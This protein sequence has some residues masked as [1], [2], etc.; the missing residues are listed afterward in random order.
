MTEKLSKANVWVRV[1]V[2]ASMIIAT[3]LATAFGLGYKLANV[4]IQFKSYVD[5]RE[6]SLRQEMDS[7]KTA[8]NTLRTDVDI[9]QKYGSA[10]AQIA[11]DT[12]LLQNTTNTAAVQRLANKIDDLVIPSLGRIEKVNEDTIKKLDEHIKVSIVK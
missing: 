7:N 11:R 8:T 3:A 9:I 10:V 12:A 4:Q 6:I 5:Q 2:N 1:G